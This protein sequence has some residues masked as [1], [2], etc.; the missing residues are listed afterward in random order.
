VSRWRAALRGLAL[1][2]VAAGVLWAVVPLLAERS[3][4]RTVL[5]V[6]SPHGRD[7]LRHYE[8]GFE[9]AHP[10][11]DVQW[12][13]LGSQEVL[14]RVQAER[15]N[16]QADV[17]FGAPADAFA[18]AA[19]QGLLAPYRPSWAA[20]V[21]AEAR[22]SL[23]RWYGTYR[24]PEVIAYNTRLVAAADAPRDWDAVLEPRW[25]G[26]VVIRDPVA[27]GSMRA[28]FGG[29]LARSVATTGSTAAGWQWLRRLDAQTRE[30]TFNPALMYERL[31]RGEALVTL[32]NMPDIATLERRTGA[33][34]TY[35]LPESGTPVLVDAIAVLRGA[36]Q[37]ALARAYYEFVTS[38]EAL[39]Y[40]ADSLQRIPARGDLPADSLPAW[41]AEANARLRPFP[42]D[43]R[44]IADSLDTWMRYWDA[45]VRNRY[46]GG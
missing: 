20:A 43:R 17:W 1:A 2:G 7:L 23:D 41:M 44:M 28:I 9:R 13:D 25:K 16:P 18:R 27:S 31:R 45:H 21:P 10:G 6:Y 30:Y 14:E 40:A 4:G 33:P 5:T 42:G 11:V 12:V 32:Y 22:D 34:V 46:R 39:L 3:D 26:K 24:T 38:R 15:A 36:R 29:I 35:V 37:P 19:A 8:T